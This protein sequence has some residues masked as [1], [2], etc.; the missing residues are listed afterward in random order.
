MLVTQFKK[1]LIKVR[2]IKDY[3]S[4]ENEILFCCCF[5]NWK[6]K[7]ANFWDRTVGKAVR[8]SQ[9]FKNNSFFV[10]KKIAY[11][12]KM[13]KGTKKYMLIILRDDNTWIS[14]EEKIRSWIGDA[15]TGKQLK[16]LVCLL[17]R[18][19]AVFLLVC[20]CTQMCLW[21]KEKRNVPTEK[22]KNKWK[23]IFQN[24]LLQYTVYCFVYLLKNIL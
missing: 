15:C 4:F 6:K 17:N 18:T 2:L 8:L 5:S 23:W 13:K 24:M 9:D 20:M 21:I 11:C 16:K 12:R 22:N 10:L 19:V 7:I 14:K 3:A 1:W